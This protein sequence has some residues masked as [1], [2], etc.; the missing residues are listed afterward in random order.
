MISE[1]IEPCD[2]LSGCQSVGETSVIAEKIHN[3]SDLVVLNEV[4]GV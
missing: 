2:F 3:L 4:M 1:P